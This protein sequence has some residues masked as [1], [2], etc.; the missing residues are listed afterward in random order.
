MALYDSFYAFRES[1]FSLSPDPRFVYLSRQHREALAGLLY[2]IC[3]AKGFALLTGE[4]GTGKTTLV[5]T[6]LTQLGDR[7]CSAVAFN[8]GMSRRGLYQHLLAEFRLPPEHSFLEATRALHMFLLAQLSEGRRVV[9]VID[10]AHALSRELLEEIRLLTNFE[11][12]RAKLL[13]VLLVGQPELVEQLQR[14]ELRQLRQ[15]VALRFELTAFD[16]AETIRYVRS[17]LASAGRTEDLFTPRAYAALYRFSGG[18]PRVINVLCDN[19]LLSG[20][21]RDQPDIDHRTIQRA[22]QDLCLS[23]QRRLGLWQRVRTRHYMQL[24][25]HPLDS[26]REIALPPLEFSR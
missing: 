10:E 11:T 12:S 1:P 19:A 6:L 23:P 3:D 7:V 20:F 14:S 24:D 25:G 4:V 9:V 16:F 26:L 15:R 21:A 17:R 18:L 8:P 5:H 22:A 13:Q 2:A